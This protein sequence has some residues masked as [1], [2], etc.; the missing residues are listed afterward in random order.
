L[1]NE[2]GDRSISKSSK[3]LISFDPEQPGQSG[4]NF[5]DG[6][7]RKLPGIVLW[8]ESEELSVASSEQPQTTCIFVGDIFDAQI[9]KSALAL[10]EDAPLEP[11]EL[12]LRAYLAWG[13]EACNR[14]K[15]I[16]SWFIWD[17]Q[18]NRLLCIRDRIGIHPI[19]FTR[20][21]SSYLLSDSIENIIQLP[22][23]S[24][25]INRAALADHLCNH[26][27]RMQETFFEQIRRVPPGNLMKISFSQEAIYRYWYVIQDEDQVNW[28]KDDEI[29]QFDHQFE[30]ATARIMNLGKP[31]IFLSGGLDSVSVAAVAADIASHRHSAPPLALSL[32]FPFP[33]INEKEIQQSVARQ[34]GLPQVLVDIYADGSD[35]QLLDA[36]IQAN[37]LLNTIPLHLWLPG[38]QRLTQEAVNAG[39]RVILTG[40][41]GDEW[42]NVSPTYAADLI[43]RFKFFDLRQLLNQ[44]INSFNA[45]SWK[46]YY[47]GIWKFGLRPMLGQLA[48]DLLLATSPDLIRKRRRDS[49]LRHQ[50]AWVAPDPHLN[51]ELVRRIDESVERSIQDQRIKSIYIR[52]MHTSLE[53]PLVAMELETSYELSRSYNIKKLAPFQDADLV[54]FLYRTPPKH[55]IKGGMAKGMVRESL[56]KRFPDLGFDTQKKRAATGFFRHVLIGQGKISWAASN[57]AEALADLGIIDPVKLDNELQDIFSGKSSPARAWLIWNILSLEAWTK[58]RL[59]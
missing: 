10:P 17:G 31:A 56:A 50:P 54:D 44:Y 42:L 55:L 34:L 1:R 9:V 29:R 52:E 43:R 27:P 6:R 59:I 30:Q 12:A 33:E 20:V 57:H 23:V 48:G 39:C 46:L 32:V 37:S 58:R 26:W 14:L 5:Q 25:E 19:Y 51:Q 3:W 53:H 15:G 16:Y 11:A 36:A 4:V 49:Y 47:Y 40:S 28:L 38:Y 41:G 18:Y 24:P 22:G 35:G 8:G 13:E 2:S 21:G 7:I 45:P